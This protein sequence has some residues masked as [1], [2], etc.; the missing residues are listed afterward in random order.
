MMHPDDH[1]SEPRQARHVA[2]GGDRFANAGA[3]RADRSVTED[4]DDPT[5]EA[6]P[7]PTLDLTVGASVLIADRALHASVKSVS[8][9]GMVKS[10]LRVLDVIE[11]LGKGPLTHGEI[12]ERLDIPRSSLTA[13]L[14]DL[15]ARG[16][17]RLDG[18]RRYQLGTRLLALAASFARD[19]DLARI[20][21][22]AV[23]ALA[24][25]ACETAAFALWSGP[26]VVAIARRNWPSPLMYSI[27][28]GDRGPLH[29]SASGQAVLAALE[30][31][32]AETIVAQLE[33]APLTAHTIT[34]PKQLLDKIART[35]A[36]G[37]AVAEEELA[38]GIVTTAAHVRD[39]LGRPIGAI[40]L[41]V[42]TPRL[43][44]RLEECRALVRNSAAEMS[45]LVAGNVGEENTPGG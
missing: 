19:L 18:A 44:G 41:S 38:I 13:L 39:D 32:E 2:A 27:Q 40:S 29:A 15:R 26:E 35:R 14:N 34:C 3:R 21:G 5:A 37:D 42:P 16:Y 1:R 24:A 6:D 25:A 20:A 22:P 43:G 11:A 12:T 10:A 36:E 31:G 28:I 9:C 4:A 45:E 17:V 7:D 33:L 8:I 30:P 23:D